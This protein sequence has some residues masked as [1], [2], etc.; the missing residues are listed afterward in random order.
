MVCSARSW[1]MSMTRSTRDSSKMLGRYS[2]GQRRMPGIEAPSVG[3]RPTICTSGF[4]SLKYRLQPMMVP[5]VP[6]EL[7]KWV[8]APPVSAQISGAVLS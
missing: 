7:T 1:S 2:L 8:M 5:V 6:M 4:C 3:C